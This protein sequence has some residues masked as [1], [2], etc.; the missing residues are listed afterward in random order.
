M[1]GEMSQSEV[2]PESYPL[3][4]EL[5]DA[6]AARGIESEPRAFDQYQGPYLY[7]SNGGIKVWYNSEDMMGETLLIE[8]GAPPCNTF[9]TKGADRV[10]KATAKTLRHGVY[11]LMGAEDRIAEMRR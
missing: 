4:F 7:I 9:E 5:R 11:S 6:L 1:A 3:L 2:T 8:R 10:L